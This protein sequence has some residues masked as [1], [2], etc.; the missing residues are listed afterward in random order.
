MS[1]R[2]DKRLK[3][4]GL[5]KKSPPNSISPSSSME[6][7]LVNSDDPGYARLLV[8]PTGPVVERRDVK[9]LDT[10]GTGEDDDGGYANPADALKMSPHMRNLPA[11]PSS[12]LVPEKECPQ[13]DDGG[14][15]NPADALRVSPRVLSLQKTPN[16]PSPP[17][18]PL[19][20]DPSSEN[21][22]AVYDSPYESVTVIRKM[23]EQQIK[24]KANDEKRVTPAAA[25]E[26]VGPQDDE[27]SGYS[28]PFDA[29]KKAKKIRSPSDASSRKPPSSLPWQRTNSNSRIGNTE[30]SARAHHQIGSPS[31]SSSKGSLEHILDEFPKRR[32][33]S[34]STAN[35]PAPKPLPRG[36]K[37][38]PPPLPPPVSSKP[39]N[40]TSVSTSGIRTGSPVNRYI[41]KVENGVSEEKENHLTRA[42][43]GRTRSVNSALNGPPPPPLRTPAKV[44][45]LRDGRAKISGKTSGPTTSSPPTAADIST[46]K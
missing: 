4:A 42:E 5:L 22:L 13:E 10:A 19:V 6:D 11:A 3:E 32:S 40:L 23:R 24:E 9:N 25:T 17:T 39:G 26:E 29:L 20:S 33:A 30:F 44:T 45:K 27:Q 31:P 1:T 46:R 37:A 15:T 34:T 21:Y 35:K 36:N 2:F 12:P 14:Y 43:S 28:R 41:L 16:T 8:T 7:D 38:D 18:S